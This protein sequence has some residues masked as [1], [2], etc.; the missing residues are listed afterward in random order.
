MYHKTAKTKMMKT[1]TQT[2]T[3]KINKLQTIK[4]K[5]QVTLKV[6]LLRRVVAFHGRI[7]KTIK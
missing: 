3:I 4:I 7:V 1:M 6:K 5:L 2:M